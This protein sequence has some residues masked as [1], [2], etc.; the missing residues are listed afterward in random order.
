[1]IIKA[2][3]ISLEH[4]FGRNAKH[5][6]KKISKAKQKNK[7]KYSLPISSLYP[8]DKAEK[9][10]AESYIYYLNDSFRKLI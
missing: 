8:G 3:S 9:V 1:M 4:S 7:Q 5:V 2:Q 6:S 10:Y